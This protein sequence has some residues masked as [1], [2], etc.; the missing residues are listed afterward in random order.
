MLVGRIAQRIIRGVIIAGLVITGGIAGAPTA[1]AHGC[2]L[3][4]LCGAVNNRTGRTMHYT[5]NLGTGSGPCDVWNKDGDWV[6]HF[7]PAHCDQKALGNGTKGGTFSGDDVD[8]FTFNS[9]GYH[10]RFFRMGTWHWRQKGV[11][12]KIQNHEIADCGIGDGNE[13]W[14]TVLVQ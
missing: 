8:A 12:T 3:G 11:W 5:T 4:A 1:S 6:S 2:T 14:C 10:E 13:I 9:E 7:W